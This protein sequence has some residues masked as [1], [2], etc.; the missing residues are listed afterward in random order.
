MVK[1]KAAVP[2]DRPQRTKEHVN[3]SKSH[4]YIEKFFIYKGHTVDR[5]GAD[6]GY[7]ILVNTYDERGYAENGEVR[8]QLKAS[9]NFTYVK[10][11]LFISYEITIQHHN[12]W[13]KEVMPVF[14]IL[15]DAAKEIAYWIYV[16]EY[17]SD[18]SRKPK[19]TAKTISVRI[20]VT[21]VFTDSTV[22]YVCACK[23]AILAS[24]QGKVVH[25]A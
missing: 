20:P 10:E 8:I 22:D 4:N 9:D 16:Q 11:E 6:Y 14:L 23:A 3:A 7:D 12:L 2:P 21:N 18:P 13:T 25:N 5:P 19:A 24:I 1:A 15:F 17:F